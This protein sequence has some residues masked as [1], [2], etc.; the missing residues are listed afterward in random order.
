MFHYFTYHSSIVNMYPF[1]TPTTISLSGISGAGKTFWVRRLI[2][3]LDL[4][5]EPCPVKVMYAYNVWQNIFSE[6]E[7]EHDFI[8]FVEGLPTENDLE[9]LLDNNPQCLILD[10]MMLECLNNARIERL[11][12]QGSHHRNLTVIF[13]NQ[14]AFCQGKNARNIN[15]NTHHMILFKNPRDTQQI[16]LLGRQLGFGKCLE[17][18]YVDALSEK[19]GYLCIDMSPHSEDLH[20]MRT[21]IFPSEDTVVYIPKK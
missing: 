16:K 2:Q 13:L 12:T 18:A 5:F 6:M 1:I 20:R 10:D 19:Y 21:N 15:L 9:N 8:N 11:F 17:E 3:N 7:K 4:M 14:N